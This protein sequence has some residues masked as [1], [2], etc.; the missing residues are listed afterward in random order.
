MPAATAPVTHPVREELRGLL[1]LAGPLVLTN[2]GN[3]LLSLVDVAV[4]GRLGE[5]A[6]AGAGL[7]NAVFFTTGLFGLGTLFGLD[8]LV[9]QALGAGEPRRAR[10]VLTQGLWL[11]ALVSIPIALV[12][13]LVAAQLENLGQEAD[14]AEM[15]RAYMLARLPS[16]LP[17]LALTAVRSYL[18]ALG[19]GRALLWG[20][21]AANVINVPVAIGLSFGVR[22]LGIPPLGVVGAGLAAGLATLVQLGVSAA[23]LRTLD[24][25]RGLSD[26]SARP[27]PVLLRRAL[28]LGGPIGVQIVLEAGSFAIVAFLVGGFGRLPLGAHQLALS[29]VSCTFQI[30]LGIAAATSV[31]VGNAVG[32]SDTAGA[33]RAGLTGIAAGGGVM[34][35]GAVLFSTVPRLIARGITDQ[36]EIVDAAVPFLLVAAAF[37]LSDGVQTVAQGALRGAGDTRLPLTLNLLGHYVIGLPVGAWLA[38]HEGLGAV[39][40]WW[41]L[42]AGLTAVAISMSARFVQISRREIAR[43]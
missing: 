43:V 23:P 21:L 33:R 12:I 2:A 36:I 28:G 7:G 6:I 35:A 1:A 39:G 27:D 31:R 17:F 15:A 24:R 16:L 32:R 40:L 22:A 10:A 18:Q 38:Y 3:M 34:I 14:V 11:A 8:P 19:H 41:G 5:A 25:E 42:S 29:C 13:V 30:A 37:Q 9:S 4:V 26:L 20:V